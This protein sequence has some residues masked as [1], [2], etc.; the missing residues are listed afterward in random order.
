MW[1]VWVGRETYAEFWL[2]NLKIAEHLEDLGVEGRVILNWIAN[3]YIGM[4]G[5]D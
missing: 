2:G 4:R 5:P 3:K 1:R